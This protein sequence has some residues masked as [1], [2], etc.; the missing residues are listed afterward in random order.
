[1][2]TKNKTKM[3]NAKITGSKK[4]K[5]NTQKSPENNKGNTKITGTTTK[6][7]KK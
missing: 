2:E 6:Q 1:M 5:K 4:R 3:G 7:N